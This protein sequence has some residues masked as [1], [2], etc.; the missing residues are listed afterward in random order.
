MLLPCTELATAVFMIMKQIQIKEKSS[1][2]E[3]EKNLTLQNVKH[4]SVMF[5]LLMRLR[6]S[7]YNILN[8]MQQHSS[9]VCSGILLHS[10]VTK[11]QILESI[12]Q[13]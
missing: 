13:Q 5:T 2:R 3:T 9:T 1:P 6:W 10:F 8:K 11:L 12:Q 4:T 7:E